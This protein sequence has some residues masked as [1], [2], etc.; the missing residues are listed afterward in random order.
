MR[1]SFYAIEKSNKKFQNFDNMTANLG[2]TV[3]FDRGP[4]YVAFAG[5]TTTP[6]PSNQLVQSLTCGS[7]LNIQS[8]F[9]DQQFLFNVEDYMRIYGY[10]AALEMGT[11]IEADMLK[12]FIS[13]QTGTD[14]N[15]SNFNV[16]NYQSGPFRFYG[17]GVTAIDSF[18]KLAQAI[19][20][21]HDFGAARNQV[22]GVLPLA[23]IPAIVGNGLNQ[24]A[25]NRNNDLAESWELGRFAECD[26]FT[27]NL[28]PIQM[29]GTI[30]N[31]TFGTNNI[32]T[33]VSTND[34]TGANVTQITFTEPTS[35][36]STSAIKAGDLMYFIDGVSG[37][38]NMRSLTYVGHQ[39]CAQSVQFRAIADAA[40]SSGTV[41]VSLQT[42]NGVGLV[43]ANNQ[44]RNLN[45]AIAA[46]M[47][48]AV[49]PSHRAGCIHS[50]DQ[51]YLAMP[52]L[53]EMT[54][55]PSSTM[56]DGD[57]GVSLRHY[58]GASFGLGQRS[59]VRDTIWGGTMVAENAM[60]LCFPM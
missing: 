7:S 12:N 48:V 25:L 31:G 11:I 53:P 42:T 49:L 34:P 29:A 6:Q 40:S 22:H 46:G 21:F 16:V 14:P 33:V 50:G 36:T 52:K 19:A 44:N 10:S 23:N 43:W 37:Q 30:G 32:M 54:P 17:D 56:Q 47:K 20:N 58:Y 15:A 9:T 51:L 39:P 28:L 60:R 8:T 26:W 57:S 24:F 3:T 2:D 1:N 41:T 13:A 5:L 4:R 55:Y 38:P 59:Y 27:S 18:Q 35:G 45:N